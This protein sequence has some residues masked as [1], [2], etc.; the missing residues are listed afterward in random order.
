MS[1]TAKHEIEKR[2]KYDK[3]NKFNQHLDKWDA[4]RAEF[5]IIAELDHV[6]PEIN[7]L[8]GLESTSNHTF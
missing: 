6:D 5:D 8:F 2:R 4:A 3:L 1:Y 7:E